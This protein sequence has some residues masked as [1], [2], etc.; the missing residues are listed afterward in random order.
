MLAEIWEL[1]I[2]CPRIPC[3]PDG[4]IVDFVPEVEGHV[5]EAQANLLCLGSRQV[6]AM[7][8]ETAWPAGRAQASN[9]SQSPSPLKVAMLLDVED[10]LGHA[11]VPQLWLSPCIET[12][13]P[14][15]WK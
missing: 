15:C 6:G 3:V 8:K 12:L 1:F 2:G 14:L 9:A 5:L 4:L 13:D 11:S 7:A 10:G